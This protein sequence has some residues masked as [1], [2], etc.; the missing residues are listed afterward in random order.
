MPRVEGEWEYNGQD[1][2]VQ[3]TLHMCGIIT[4]KCPHIINV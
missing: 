1:E 3:G 2:F 4:M